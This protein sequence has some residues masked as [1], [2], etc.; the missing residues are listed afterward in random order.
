MKVL[1]IIPAYNE[2]ESIASVLEEVKSVCAEHPGWDVLVVNDCSRDS[3]P[4]ILR[5]LGVPHLNLPCNLGIGGCVQAGYRYARENGYEVALQ[6]DADGQHIAEY[7]P[8][9]IRPFEEGRAEFVIG[10]RVLMGSGYRSTA[11]RR[12]GGRFLSA[13][14]H[15]L[16]GVRVLDVT[17]GMRAIGRPLIEIFALGDYSQ[18]YPEAESILYTGVRGMRVVEVPVEMRERQYGSSS[19]GAFSSV[20]FM[21]KVSLSLLLLRTSL[22]R[23]RHA[24]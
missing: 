7:I 19:I 8:A 4:E 3:T 1:I 15:L 11:L 23:D 2:E 24:Q 10:S 6:F 9:M 18:D 13:L 17:S 5:S 12:A 20:Y 16:S 22:R 14:L 21:L